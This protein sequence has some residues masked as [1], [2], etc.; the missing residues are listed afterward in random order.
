[1]QFHLLPFP[2]VV[3]HAVTRDAGVAGDARLMVIRIAPGYEADQGLLEHERE[4]VRQFYLAGILAALAVSVALIALVSLDA[5]QAWLA[6]WPMGYG[7]AGVGAVW[8]FAACVA[9]GAAHSVLYRRVRDYRLFAEIAAY[10]VQMRYP[11]RHGQSMSALT[12]A[13]RLALP[14]YR[15]EITQYEAMQL[16]Q[17][18]D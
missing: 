8:A 1:M 10:R 14:M 12:G 3:I 11:D 16:L 13:H 6:S 18:H 5:L 9:F 2:H 17:P 15:L 7:A 4:H